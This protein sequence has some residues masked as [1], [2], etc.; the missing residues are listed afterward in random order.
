MTWDSFFLYEPLPAKGSVKDLFN[1]L[2]QQPDEERRNE[3]EKRL[4]QIGAY[5]RKLFQQRLRHYD[6][7]LGNWMLTDVG[8]GLIDTDS[9]ARARVT[10][11]ML[12]TFFDLACFKRLNL[13]PG[14]ERRVLQQCLGE[15]YHERWW[16]VHRFWRFGLWRRLRGKKRRSLR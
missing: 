1:G 7:A 13:P 12:K 5:L 9:V 15:A 4:D 11:P 3:Y 16:K 8:V 6:L 2:Q 14:E 10:L